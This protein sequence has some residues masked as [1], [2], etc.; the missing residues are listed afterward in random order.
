MLVFWRN[1]PDVSVFAIN[2]F[3]YSVCGSHLIA[4]TREGVLLA[5]SLV[6]LLGSSCSFSGV[7][8]VGLSLS[9]DRRTSVYSPGPPL[10]LSLPSP[11]WTCQLGVLP[12]FLSPIERVPAKGR[13]KDITSVAAALADYGG[14]LVRHGVWGGEL[15]TG[16]GEWFLL[17][18]GHEGDYRLGD[19]SLNN[20]MGIPSSTTGKGAGEGE[21]D[22]ALNQGGPK[23]SNKAD[24]AENRLG[25]RESHKG[26][27]AH[28]E[29]VR[30]P[31]SLNPV[32]DGTVLSPILGGTART[33]S[34]C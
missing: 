7:P 27:L 6:S 17:S 34:K 28:S 24:L 2:F 19:V 14:C 29:D 25:E 30:E 33:K 12:L 20:H 3:L 11:V 10:F 15:Q 18:V 5:Y 16:S 21:G 32:L 8:A 9:E 26:R 23:E 4:G 1:A 22:T 13:E 31:S